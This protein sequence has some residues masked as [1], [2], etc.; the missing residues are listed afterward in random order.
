MEGLSSDLL[1]R[2]GHAAR[3]LGVRMHSLNSAIERALRVWESTER[4]AAR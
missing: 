3:T 1:P 4:L 2:D